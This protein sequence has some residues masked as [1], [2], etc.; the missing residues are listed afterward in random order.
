MWNLHSVKFI[1][2]TAN[3]IG[4]TNDIS[5]LCTPHGQRLKE[6][7]RSPFRYMLSLD[8]LSNIYK[9]NLFLNLLSTI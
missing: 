2:R 5:V 4:T 7:M 1:L 9:V 8:I 6:E 3:I